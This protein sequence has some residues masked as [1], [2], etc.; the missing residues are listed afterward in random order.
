M[1]FDNP[2]DLDYSPLL[3]GCKNFFVKPVVWWRKNIVEPNQKTYYWYHRK[4]QRVPTVDNCYDDDAVCK[5]E[6][7]RQMKRDRRVEARICYILKSK[8]DDC[9]FYEG[10]GDAR[11]LCEPYLKHFEDASEAYFI[12]YGDLGWDINAEQVFFRQKH[13]LIW[14]RRHGEVGTGMKDKDGN[15]IPLEKLKLEDGKVQ[16][17]SF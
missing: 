4:F 13:R 2:D 1:V 5:Y 17:G 14:E 11:R 10:E 15:R 12:K 3:T 8:F 6:A 16:Y 7:T 9:V